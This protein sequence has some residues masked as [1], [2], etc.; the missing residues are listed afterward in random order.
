MKE[1]EMKMAC[2]VSGILVYENNR[3]CHLIQDAVMKIVH[4]T[5]L[6]V[7]SAQHLLAQLFYPVKRDN[8]WGFIDSTGQIKIPLK[9]DAAL[10]FD[11]DWISAPV[12]LNNKWGLIDPSGHWILEPTY[13]QFDTWSNSTYRVL[14]GVET[15]W[16][17]RRGAVVPEDDIGHSS[18]DLFSETIDTVHFADGRRVVIRG[19]KYGYADSTG[20][21]VIPARYDDVESFANGLAE[22]NIGAK[23]K[24]DGGSKAGGKWGAI[25]RAGNVVIPLIYDEILSTNGGAYR[26][27]EWYKVRNGNRYGLYTNKGR[28]VIPLHWGE[29]DPLGEELFVVAPLP[30]KAEQD[31]LDK[32][33]RFY[34]RST[35]PKGVI[36]QSEKNILPYRYKSVR[37][38]HAGQFIV[39][40]D[41]HD[42]IVDSENNWIVEPIYD[43]ILNTY[44]NLYVVTQKQPGRIDR[45]IDELYEVGLT[46]LDNQIASV[47]DTAGRCV[48]E[49]YWR[50]IMPIRDMPGIFEV[51]HEDYGTAIISWEG[52]TILQPGP[53]RG[54]W[55]VDSTLI[56]VKMN[57][58][59]YGAIRPDGSMTSIR[60]DGGS[61]FADGVA[62]VRRGRET[63]RGE[64]TYVIDTTGTSLFLLDSLN[65]RWRAD[66]H[67]GNGLIALE[68]QTELASGERPVSFFDH[69][70]RKVLGPYLDARGFCEGVAAVRCDSGS[71]SGDF[72]FIDTEGMMVIPPRFADAG[73]FSEGLAPVS[74]KIED[75]I[76]WGYINH[77]GEW[78]IKPQFGKARSFSDGLAAVL[79]WTDSAMIREYSGCFLV[80]ERY[81]RIGKWG[82]INT[83]GEFV[84]P[85]TYRHAY[86]FHDGIASVWTDSGDVLIDH[87]GTWLFSPSK[88][89]WIGEYSEGKAPATLSFFLGG[90]THDDVGY[91]DKDG[92][93]VIAPRFATG[94]PFRSN[95]AIIVSSFHDTF[96]Y[97]NT[98]GEVIWQE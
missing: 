11:D 88:F 97:V 96:I 53:Y 81:D 93:W 2:L 67:Q 50:R 77:D 17:D 72:G 4:L 80:E 61:D 83:E 66:E 25:D 27:K 78:V 58:L 24:V 38:G 51:Q 42:G 31:S 48:I 90:Y 1:R 49:P 85:I 3:S 55:P 7:L 40:T 57:F 20:R 30:N 32:L 62:T 70:G 64:K 10:E 16:I 94:G 82:F 89:N 26:R 44:N 63:V 54:I 5:L 8:R 71:H 59:N 39:R 6:I 45:D 37:L 84:L 56:Q 60:F 21:L 14:K 73:Q 92:E 13:D 9:Y 98:R 41:V 52:D 79:E 69:T 28:L 91:I 36:D 87:N 15:V 76:K 74:V 43:M 86:D 35:L 68:S 47:I 22:V 23:E 65:M 95:R 75:D 34:P 12:L 18:F 29:V 19:G 33:S 46:W